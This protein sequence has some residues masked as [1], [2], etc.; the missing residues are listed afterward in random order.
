MMNRIQLLTSGAGLAVLML[1]ATPSVAGSGQNNNPGAQCAPGR[2]SCVIHC[3]PGRPGCRPASG[4]YVYQPQSD[5]Y[6]ENH[7]GIFNAYPVQPARG[8]SC[9]AAEEALEDRGYRNISV[10][11]CDGGRYDFTASKNGRRYY[12]TFN[13]RTGR[14][15]REAM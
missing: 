5:N 15:R 10:K 9:N 3:T 2:P 14:I 1:W 6:A 13:A 12:I 7:G 8:Y 11:D 4:Y